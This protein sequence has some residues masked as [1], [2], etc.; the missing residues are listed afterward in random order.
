V[1]LTTHPHLSTEVVEWVE[2]LPF[3][4]FLDRSMF[5]IFFNLI[6]VC[7]L[8]QR[9]VDGVQGWRTAKFMDLHSCK[10]RVVPF[11][12]ET[13]H[14]KCTNKPCNSNIIRSGT[15][16]LGRPFRFKNKFFQIYSL[17]F[18]L[19]KLL[20]LFDIQNILSVH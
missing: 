6:Y 14:L 20:I 5:N 15:I 4:D 12:R 9:H 2:L 1:A 3:W 19:L 8:V 13:T 18:S 7:T 16:C 11:T 10:T 17:Y